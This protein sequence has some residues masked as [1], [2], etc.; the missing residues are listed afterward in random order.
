M[1]NRLVSRCVFA[2]LICG[3][4]FPN[5]S[6]PLVNIF[7]GTCTAADDT[8][9]IVK[10]LLK[11]FWTATKKTQANDFFA[12][13]TVKNFETVYAFALVKSRQHDVKAALKA[14]DQLEAIDPTKAKPQRLK[15]WL[16]LRQ[17]KFNLAITSLA[18]YIE[19]VKAD[20]TLNDFARTEAYRFAGRVFAFLEGPVQGRASKLSLDTTKRKIL[21]K[22]DPDLL[23]AFNFDYAV[24]EK[25]YQEMIGKKQT[26]DQNAAR[27]D[28]EKRKMKFAQLTE[29]EKQ[30]A[31][32]KDQ[33]VE[34]SSELRTEATRA[35]EELRLQDAPLAL[36]QSQLESELNLINRELFLMISDYNY[37]NTL[38]LRENNQ[39]LR[40][41]YFQRAG[42]ADG[43]ILRAELDANSVRSQLNVVE[44]QRNDL[45]RQYAAIDSS[46]S[47]Q[48]ASLNNGLKDIDKQKRR[49]ANEKIKTT[50]PSR[51]TVTQSMSLRIRSQSIATFDQFPLEIERQLIL[52]S[53]K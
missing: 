35:L 31:E 33:I 14:L 44:S 40:I 50:K 48:L 13:Q 38:A 9:E 32:N 5:S 47:Q 52:D 10:K 39:R 30:L 34:K 28:A 27:V 22:L 20:K 26:I 18:K 2:I 49:T 51:K 23:S 41:L 1:N 53:L 11:D 19:L 36:Q 42:R 4:A 8:D 46:A 29:V 45:R 24:V 25:E 12:S 17:N 43:L 21:F 16:L 15:T 6:L 7:S 37:W 3:I